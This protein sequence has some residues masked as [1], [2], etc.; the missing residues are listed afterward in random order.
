MYNLTVG[1]DLKQFPLFSFITYLRD[2]HYFKYCYE[3]IIRSHIKT[4]NSK[5]EAE[6][7]AQHYFATLDETKYNVLPYVN[8]FTLDKEVSYPDI[9]QYI[10]YYQKITPDF[11]QEFAEYLT[12]DAKS[13]YFVKESSGYRLKT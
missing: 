10:Q 7:A 12:E 6:A 13:R 5:E 2:K 11:I 1:E 3:L 9:A 8:I 4:Y